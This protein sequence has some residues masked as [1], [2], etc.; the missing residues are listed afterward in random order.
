MATPANT[1]R[2]APAR[3]RA[4]KAEHLS[5][6][7]PD[8]PGVEHPHFWLAA[9]LAKHA[10]RVAIEHL[11]KKMS[12]PGKTTLHALWTAIGHLIQEERKTAEYLCKDG[13]LLYAWPGTKLFTNHQA[14]H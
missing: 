9:Y 12:K 10:E 14:R 11:E 4:P 13:L 5:M 1:E 2:K 3:R 6:A 8:L 7:H